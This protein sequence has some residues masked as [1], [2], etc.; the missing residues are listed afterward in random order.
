MVFCCKG[1]SEFLSN[2]DADQT[3][4]DD[5]VLSFEA[6]ATA[7]SLGAWASP[8]VNDPQPGVWTQ[9]SADTSTGSTGPNG[10][11]SPGTL[12]PSNSFGFAYTETSPAGGPATFSLEGPSLDASLGVC[13]LTFVYHMRFGNGQLTDGSLQVQG[14]NGTTWQNI[15]AAIVGSQQTTGDDPYLRSEA[16]GT[17]DST[18]F[19]NA[20]FR[21][22]FLATRGAGNGSLPDFNYDTAVDTLEISGPTGAL[23]DA[24]GGGG[25]P[26]GGGGGP[27]V[28]IFQEFS[29]ANGVDAWPGT[30][31]LSN[32]EQ[33]HN[34]VNATSAPFILSGTRS[35]RTETRRGDPKAF[36]DRNTS[37]PKRRQEF[38]GFPFRFAGNGA[39]GY[40]GYYCYLPSS[41]MATVRGVTF[42]QLHNFPEAGEMLQISVTNGFMN[43][44]CD[45]PGKNT[46][47]GRENLTTFNGT[48]LLDRR[49]KVVG[50]FRPST[51][52]NGFMNIF[53][54]GVQVV[55]FSG[56]TKPSGNDGPYFKFGGYFWG[57]DEGANN[58]D[59]IVIHDN[60][61][62]GDSTSSLIDV[63]P[64]N[65]PR[66]GL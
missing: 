29:G 58:D 22:R 19:N 36:V 1:T 49:F 40:F 27:A 14:W 24:G 13:T 31:N 46:P 34:R 45:G 6:F 37:T 11:A 5:E 20:D 7:G 25:D 53:I 56:P 63:D 3:G 32:P 15:G 42:Q 41:P 61:R 9:R 33:A 43:F 50:E 59:A 30:L 62:L 60:I 51:T 28:G 39:I 21:F 57:Y 17:F 26:G 8:G 52:N 55:N 2:G 44:S 16:L 12:I 10:G 64:D 47:V 65:F 38:S 35:L 23:N 48:G 4:Q 66:P 54:D 18:G